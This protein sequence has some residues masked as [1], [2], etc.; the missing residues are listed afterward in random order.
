MTNAAWNWHP[1]GN[2]AQRMQ[3]GLSTRGDRHG[4]YPILRMNCLLDG[5]VLLRDLQFIDLDDETASD[6]RLRPGD[7][8]FNRT[9]SYELVGRTGLVEE[10]TE[11]VFASYLVRV[12]V[13]DS[14]V[15]PRFLNFFLNWEATQQELRKLASRGVGQA[16]ISA[17]KLRDFLI[18]TPPIEEQRSIAA[19]LNQVRKAISLN[20]RCTEVAED[21]KRAAMRTLFTRGLRGEPQKET[22]IGP[23]PQSWDVVSFGSIR[24]RLQYGTSVRCTYEPM[25]V[26]VLRIP[27]I[28]SGRVNVSELKFGKLSVDEAD[29]YRLVNGDLIFIRTNGVLERLGSCAVYMGEPANASFA[30]YLIRAQLK[31]DKVDPR[32]AAFFYGSEMGTGIVA[33]RATPAADG[34][35]NLNTG[36]IDSLPLPLPPT[37][38]EQREVVTVLDALDRKI[39]LHRRKG[40][41]LDQLFK[42]LLHRLMVGEVRVGD[43]DLSALSL[44]KVAEAAA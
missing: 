23:A 26:P 44:P 20:H 12:S 16:N 27:N 13:D 43:L 31:R 18:P 19:G 8:L 3:Y 17:G 5:K 6:F 9:N 28:E 33:G 15:D 11:A 1:L 7:I 40:V 42:S 29:R 14:K 32:F 22:E 38:D 39:D 4:R 35:Y 37:L 36:T 24:E 2:F 30:S 21:L 41:A 34:K 10:D 25:G